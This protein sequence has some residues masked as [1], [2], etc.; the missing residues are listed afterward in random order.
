MQEPRIV[1]TELRK[2][3][4]EL[5]RVQALRGGAKVA[6]PVAVDVSVH[7]GEAVA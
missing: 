3:L 7:P 5:Q 6:A 2:A 1:S 4:H